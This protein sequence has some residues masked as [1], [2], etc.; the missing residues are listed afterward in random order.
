MAIRKYADAKRVQFVFYND[1]KN[2]LAKIDILI[3]LD[4]SERYE[5]K[6]QREI[7]NAYIDSNHQWITRSL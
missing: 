2:N 4:N 3:H 6:Q 5:N 7:W 1:V